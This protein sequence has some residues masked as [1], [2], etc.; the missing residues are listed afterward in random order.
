MRP[1]P[2]AAD[3]QPDSP[4]RICFVCTGNICRSPSA[5]VVLRARLAEAGW[6]DRVVVDSAGTG[7]WHAGNDMDPRAREA[8]V[9][10]GYAPP[11]HVA[12]QFGAGD[13]ADRDLVIALDGGH[14]ARLGQLARLA[15]D[16]SDATA[17]ISLLRGFDPVA[18]AA[19]ELDIEDP[20]YDGEAGFDAV[21]A[22]IEAACAGLVG[23]L[24]R[25]LR[26]GGTEPARYLAASGGTDGAEG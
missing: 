12:K 5:E 19:G 20:Y 6:A 16:P 8:L 15:D 26:T 25:W 17:S 14:R 1:E 22:H 4:I 10:R 13:F 2:S 24:D 23:M 21:L 18:V 11:V 9:R 3:A 7:P